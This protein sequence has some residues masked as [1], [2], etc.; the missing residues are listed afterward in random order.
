[1]YNLIFLK[2]K[3]KRIFFSNQ[4]NNNECFSK[5]ILYFKCY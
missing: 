3:I 5:I 4:S 1:M 2:E